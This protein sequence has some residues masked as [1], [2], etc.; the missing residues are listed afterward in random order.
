MKNHINLRSLSFVMYR[1]PQ[2]RRPARLLLPLAL[3][4]LIG[5]K[6]SPKMNQNNGEYIPPAICAE[7]AVLPKVASVWIDDTHATGRTFGDSDVAFDL[8]GNLVSVDLQGNVVRRAHDGTLTVLAEHVVRTGRGLAYLS[9]GELVIADSGRGMLVKVYPNGESRILVPHLDYP[10][11]LDVDRDDT[12]YVSESSR[13]A[14]SRVHPRTGALTTVAQ[15]LP[16]SPNGLS[17]SPDYKTLYVVGSDASIYAMTRD[18]SGTWGPLVNFATVPGVTLTCDGKTAGD[19]CEENG[20]SGTCQDDGF[21]GLVCQGE[22]PC[23]GKAVGDACSE[24]GSSGTCQDDGAGGLYCRPVQA[25]DGKVLGDACSENGSDGTCQD[26]GGGGLTCVPT[27][28]CD[29]KAVGDACREWSTPGT[30]Q[31]NGAGGLYCQPLSACDG[32]AAGDPCYYSAQVGTCLDNGGALTCTLPQ[33][34]DGKIAGDACTE[35]GLSGTC[36]DNGGGGLYCLTVPPCEGKVAGDAC[37][38][39]GSPGTCVDFGGGYL[40]CQ[41]VPPCEGKVVGDSCNAYGT[42]G[43]CVDYGGYLDCQPTP[44]CEG[45]IVGDACVSYGS[46]G[47]CVDYGGYLECMVIPPCD[48]KISGDACDNNGLPGI[49]TD[50]LTG[51]FY[52]QSTILCQGLAE[53]AT[54]VD[55]DMGQPGRCTTTAGGLA[56]ALA[57]PCTV[58]G[59]TCVIPGGRYDGYSPAPGATGA[60]EDRM[61]IPPE[62]TVGF[63]ELSGTGLLFCAPRGAC[64]GL[65]AGDPCTTD[66][67]TSG[68]C[69]DDGAGNLYCQEPMRVCDGSVPGD[70]CTTSQGQAGFCT[71]DGFGNLVCLENPCMDLTAG[72]DCTFSSG[73]TG[74][75]VDDGAGGLFCRPDPACEG[76][77]AGDAC[78]DTRD[79]APGLCAEGAGDL[80]VCQPT[81]PC[82]GKT[83]GDACVAIGGHTGVCTDLGLGG[84]LFCEAGRPGGALHAVSTDACGNV[85]VSDASTRALWRFT[86]AGAAELVAS[87]LPAPI[88][89]L[90]WGSGAGSW[91]ALTLYAGLQGGAGVTAITLGIPGRPIVAPK[92]ADVRPST[93]PDDPEVDCLNIPDAPLSTTELPGP[94]DPGPRGYHDVV[95]DSEGWMIGSNDAGDLVRV[96][97]SGTVQ[98]FA[99]GVNGAQGLA[100]LPDGTLVAATADGLITIAPNGARDTLLEGFQGY[101]L[102]VGP[103]G[104]VYSADNSIVVRVNPLTKAREDFLV[105]SAYNQT[106]GARTI[107][108]DPDHSLMYIG[109]FGDSVYVVA[110]DEDFNIVGVPHKLGLVVAGGMFLDGFVV[111]TCGNLYL[112]NYGTSA[113]YRLSPDGVSKLYHQFTFE[114]YGHGGEWGAAAGGWRGDAIYMPQPYDGYTVTEVVV[115]IPGQ[116]H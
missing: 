82:E 105:P 9:T 78:I 114:Q 108:F 79:Q 32:K 102:T 36:T 106:W 112:P 47:T 1:L 60:A 61:V 38:Y 17:F 33:V 23:T 109:S 85:Y 25:C 52:C 63:C 83:A 11:G 3:F 50:A 92:N 96:S 51:A 101:G 55:M 110:L 104:M 18:E 14:I 19:A 37:N 57:N 12:I 68:T 64:W 56:C 13:A 70:P 21:G 39:Y 20:L 81:L 103:D 8:A 111:D 59:E 113:L 98:P 72:D 54:C 95:F 88:T 7:Q 4:W 45:K 35:N 76:K 90:L 66:W 15:G 22:T 53:G 67:G 100:F 28:V 16:M 31:D 71:N 73:A 49:C 97:Q 115:G 26:D 91:D 80:L 34:C 62:D 74:T 41:P 27:P 94:L 40:D 69:S 42:P 43:T 77:T 30:C 44:P 89:G 24:W 116:G 10:N 46:A 93:P 65:T 75:C 5:C 84:A 29:G 6:D 99:T 86:P 87:N 2:L 58:Q 107:A 48:G